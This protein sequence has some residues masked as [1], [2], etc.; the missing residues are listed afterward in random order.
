MSTPNENYIIL[1]KEGYENIEKELEELKSVRRKEVSDKLKVARS[2]GDLSE[3]AEYD[4][5]KNEQA[6]LEERITKLE[7]ILRKAEI[8]SESDMKMNVV[9]VG[10]TVKFFI[11]Y[12]DG[13]VEEE[14]Y[15]IVG[16]AEANPS[17]G[18]ISNES[19]IGKSLLG[20]KKGQKVDVQVPDGIAKLKILSIAY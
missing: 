1:T 9:N 16:S 12:P 2:F 4:E 20:T 13:E 14:E 8:I 6:Q 3:N 7:N 17:E 18:K 15:T 10:S 11:K 5:A 19:P